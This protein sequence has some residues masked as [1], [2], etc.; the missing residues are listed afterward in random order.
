MTGLFYFGSTVIRG[1][2]VPTLSTVLSCLARAQ[3]CV[4]AQAR[5]T[6]PAGIVLHE[7]LSGKQCD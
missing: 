2:I 3:D 7:N 6:D 4:Q 1:S 5:R